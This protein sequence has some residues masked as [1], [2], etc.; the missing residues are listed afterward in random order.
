[1]DTSAGVISENGD[2]ENDTVGWASI[3]KMILPV[4]NWVMRCWHGYVCSE[5]QVICIWSSWWHCHL[6]ISC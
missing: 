2:A 3:R 4:K 5:V 6:I 1:L